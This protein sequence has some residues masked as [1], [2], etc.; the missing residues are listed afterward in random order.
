MLS[1]VLS[2]ADVNA[3]LEAHPAGPFT[4]V[5]IGPEQDGLGPGAEVEQ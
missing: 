5:Q 4:T 2:V 3:A 1:E